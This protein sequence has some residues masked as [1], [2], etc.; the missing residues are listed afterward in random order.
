MKIATHKKRI[1]AII[2]G[3]SCIAFILS[4]FSFVNGSK[5]LQQNALIIKS[6]DPLIKVTRDLSASTTE[7]LVYDVAKNED[8]NIQ[9]VV[10]NNVAV[11]DLTAQMQS[12]AKINY[13]VRR[14]DYVTIKQKATGISNRLN[15]SDG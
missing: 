14:V 12:S 10:W 4:I 8:V 15:P 9:F 7:T 2:T 6:I 11:N 3:I 1:T 5:K 13:I